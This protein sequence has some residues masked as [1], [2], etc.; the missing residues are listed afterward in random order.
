MMYPRLK[1]LLK[2]LLYTIIGVILFVGIY[3]GA[4]YSL[5]RI[6]GISNNAAPKETDYTIYLLSNGV[7][8]DLVLPIENEFIDWNSL[9][10]YANTKSQSTDYQYIAIGWGDKGFY[11]NTPEWK[12]LKFSTAFNAVFGLG[13]T[14]LHVTYHNHIAP[15]ELCKPYKIK[16]TQYEIIVNY[17]KSS[18]D[19]TVQQKS[20][21][22]PT[23]AQYGDDDAF[24][25]ARGAYSLFHTCNTWTNTALKRAQL[26]CGIW[27]AFDKGI[28]SWY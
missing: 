1:R 26:P 12:D 4:E 17:V 16:A 24:Y 22:I 7:H 10:P 5:S 28:M 27:A 9:F 25:E 23:A 13:E 11:L 15:N 20:I 3:V 19:T 14:A 18:L 21:Y 6:S 2:L 8:T